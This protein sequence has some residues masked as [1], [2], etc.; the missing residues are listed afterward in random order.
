M[1]VNNLDLFSNNNVSKDGEKR[2][3]GWKGAFTIYNQE[4]HM[5]DLET[6]GE[7]AN[8]R[9]ALISMGDNNNFVTA[10]NQLR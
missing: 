10:V 2:E 1:A 8:A 3:D 5:V 6:V 7:I 9:S 4:R